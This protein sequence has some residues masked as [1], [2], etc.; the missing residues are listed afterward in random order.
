MTLWGGAAP[1]GCPA[2]ASPLRP[3][4]RGRE[5]PGLP[6]CPPLSAPPPP[7]PARIGAPVQVLQGQ[8]ERAHGLEVT[9]AW[10]RSQVQPLFCYWAALRTGTRLH[11]NSRKKKLN[12]NSL[13]QDTRGGKTLTIN[14]PRSAKYAVVD[15]SHLWLGSSRP[16]KRG[17]PPR[18]LGGCGIHRTSGSMQ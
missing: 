9:T 6:R 12:S 17:Q 18:V 4:G 16:S 1:P 13:Y 10:R 11:H 7:E 15:R 3:A 8:E 14:V 5:G 2:A